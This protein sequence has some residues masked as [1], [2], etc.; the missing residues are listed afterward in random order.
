MENVRKICKLPSLIIV[1]FT[2][3]TCVCWLIRWSL[4]N[5]FLNWQGS[6]TSMLLSENLILMRSCASTKTEHPTPIENKKFSKQRSHPNRISSIFITLGAFWNKIIKSPPPLTHPD[7]RCS[8]S[9]RESSSVTNAWSWEGV[10]QNL[11]IFALRKIN[12]CSEDQK[13]LSEL[14]VMSKMHIHT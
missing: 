5:D 8:I 7:G 9:S 1:S 14:I 13:A 3:L 4:C 10:I 6:Y 12:K 11:S 2:S